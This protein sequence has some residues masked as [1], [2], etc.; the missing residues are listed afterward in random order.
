MISKVVVS[1]AGRGTRMLHLGKQKPKHLIEINGK[2]FLY[3]LLNNLKQAGFTEIIMIIGYKKELMEDFL[4]KFN[5]TFNITI[6]NQFA[7]YAIRSYK[8]TILCS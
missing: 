3:Y 6:I 8:T 5:G 7:K 2:P 1:A 4:N